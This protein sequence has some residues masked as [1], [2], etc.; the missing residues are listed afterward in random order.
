MRMISFGRGDGN[1]QM[2]E[3]KDKEDDINAARAC[4]LKKIPDDVKPIFFFN[5]RPKQDEDDEDLACGTNTPAFIESIHGSECAS[6]LE[7]YK[8]TG[9]L[10][11][12]SRLTRNNI[13][14]GLIKNHKS[15]GHLVRKGSSIFINK[16]TIINNIITDT[17]KIRFDRVSKAYTR[18]MQLK[19]VATVQSPIVP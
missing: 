10:C 6:T 17:A 8:K 2:E 14:A 19:G 12:Q 18:N 11:D 15:Q 13:A 4:A 9:P 3:G 1:L 16:A 5:V 7:T